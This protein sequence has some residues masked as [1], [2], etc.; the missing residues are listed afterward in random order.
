MEIQNYKL[1]SLYSF[2]CPRQSNV[3]YLD[4]IERLGHYFKCLKSTFEHC[5]RLGHLLILNVLN[6]LLNIVFC[7]YESNNAKE[8]GINRI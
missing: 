3:N 5:E 8:N 6:L 7:N 4:C 1:L 2:E